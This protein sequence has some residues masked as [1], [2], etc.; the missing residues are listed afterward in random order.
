MKRN[1][2]QGV[3]FHTHTKYARKIVIP[4]LRHDY[5]VNTIIVMG[6]LSLFREPALVARISKK[7]W[8]FW[9]PN[10]S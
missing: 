3:V 6:S 1:G 8:Q 4:W 9:L 7:N 5:D 10:G 2:Q